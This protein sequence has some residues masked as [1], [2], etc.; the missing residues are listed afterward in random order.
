[1]LYPSGR[2]VMPGFGQRSPRTGADLPDAGAA[3][4]GPGCRADARKLTFAGVT[5]VCMGRPLLLTAGSGQS[6]GLARHSAV[7]GQATFRPLHAC[8]YGDAGLLASRRAPLPVNE[9]FFAK[10]APGGH[11]GG[12]RALLRHRRAGR[13]WRC[14]YGSF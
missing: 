9:R 13:A 4:C 5:Y 11:W 8:C 7:W 2:H 14:P 6:L 1:M 12:W 3:A 10:T